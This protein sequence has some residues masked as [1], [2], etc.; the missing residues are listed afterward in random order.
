MFNQ[1]ELVVDQKQAWN[2]GFEAPRREITA[3][4][5]GDFLVNN[6]RR[7]LAKAPQELRWVRILNGV[8]SICTK[9]VIL[10]FKTPGCLDGFYCLSSEGD[11]LPTRGPRV[12]GFPDL[13]AVRPIKSELQ[14]SRQIER[15][16]VHGLLMFTQDVIKSD[17]MNYGKGDIILDFEGAYARH[18]KGHTFPFYYPP[19]LPFTG[20][21]ISVSAEALSIALTECLRY[22]HINIAHE[23]D[24][25]KNNLAIF[26]MD[27][28]NS[29]SV[30]PNHNS[31]KL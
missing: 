21:G 29:A 19:N 17:R 9:E 31:R 18:N 5:P 14:V 1:Q 28:D 11:L 20:D 25:D 30:V 7:L 10:R 8:G 3:P 13:D 6:W 2:P 26:G 4:Q 27:W 12:L 23:A 16:E 24:P 22:E 15:Q